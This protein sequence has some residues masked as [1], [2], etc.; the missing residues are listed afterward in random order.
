MNR[1]F[2]AL[3]FLAAVLGVGMVNSAEACYCGGA[4]CAACCWTSCCCTVP[5]QCCTVMQT[6]QKVIYEPQRH[7]CYRTCYEPVWEQKPI[8]CV[9]YVPEV[10][11]RQCVETVCRPVYETHEQQV[12]YTVCQPVKEMVT[13]PVC[14]GHWETHNV[15][16]CSS[17]CARAR[18]A[19]VA[20]PEDG[21]M[22]GLE[23]GDHPAA[24]RVRSLRA[25]DDDENGALHDLQIGAR[26]ADFPSAV[27]GLQARAVSDDDPLRS[28]RAQA[29]G[30][31]RDVLRAAGGHRASAGAS[32]LSG[33]VVL[34]RMWLRPLTISGN[35]ECRRR[36]P[37]P[38]CG[39]VPLRSAS[40]DASYS[41]FCAVDRRRRSPRRNATTP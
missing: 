39:A 4:Q 25:A 2:S 16:C 38:T 23:A 8:T 33:A 28:L 24:G 37:S 41:H 18:A 10:H 22:P 13:V 9:R 5:Q 40:G 21:A 11:Y 14:S 7:T 31:H 6:C 17:C 32:M 3:V 19:R 27:H 35:S 26:A 30:L 20:M 1:R 34:R 29:G 15:P 12:C 36:L